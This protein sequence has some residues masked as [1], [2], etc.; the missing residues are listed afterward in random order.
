VKSLSLKEHSMNQRAMILAL[1]SDFCDAQVS[2]K[3][4]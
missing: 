3:N 2:K 4:N 1:Y